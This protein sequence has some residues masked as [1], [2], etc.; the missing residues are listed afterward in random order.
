MT[1]TAI[2]VKADERREE[3]LATLLGKSEAKEAAEA[4]ALVPVKPASTAL[5][6]TGDATQDYLNEHATS[7]IPGTGIRYDGKDGKFVTFDKTPL[8]DTETAT[9]VFLSDQVWAGWIKFDRDGETK[10]ERI[11]G[12][13]SEGFKLPARADLDETDPDLWTVGLS[14]KPED[15]W[16]HEVIILL[17]NCST[18][19]MLAFHAMNPTSRGACFDL[20]NHC[21]RRKRTGHDDYPLIRLKSGSYERREPPKVRVHKPMFAVVGHQPKTTIIEKTDASIG[22]DLSDKIPF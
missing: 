16:K 13:I 4:K 3:G 21:Q 12:L 17:Q 2:Y 22:A 8:P 15:P 11:Q 19:E 14:G 18:G 20:M 7:L 9:F 5:T 10:P 6:T 1:K